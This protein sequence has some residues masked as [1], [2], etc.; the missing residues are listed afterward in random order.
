MED[1]EFNVAGA[2]FLEHSGRFVEAAKLRFAEGQIVRAISLLLRD[3]SPSSWIQA[4]SYI[5]EGLWKYFPFGTTVQFRQDCGFKEEDHFLDDI[6][7][8]SEQFLD[9]RSPMVWDH[10]KDQ[11]RS[12]T[13]CRLRNF[14]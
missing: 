13:T 10:T 14:S 3:R 6:L 1:Y 7:R 9:L 11:V 5:L 2:D 8:L 12:H 4:E